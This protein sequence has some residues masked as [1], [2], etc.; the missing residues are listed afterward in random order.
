VL[1]GIEIRKP[2]QPDSTRMRS[3]RTSTRLE[4]NHLDAPNIRSLGSQWARSKE[5]RTSSPSPPALNQLRLILSE[6]GRLAP[7][8]THKPPR[9]SITNCNYF[10]ASRHRDARSAGRAECHRR[11]LRCPH[12]AGCGDSF[13]IESLAA[14]GFVEHDSNSTPAST[15]LR[16]KQQHNLKLDD[17]TR[18][19]QPHH[20]ETRRLGTVTPPRRACSMPIGMSPLHFTY[21]VG[22]AESTRGSVGYDSLRLPPSAARSPAGLTSTGESPMSR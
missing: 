8:F 14:I 12:Q 10:D 11:E 2:V 13:R 21:Q 20:T 9:A 1:E 22:S 15:Q 19:P 4:Q 16:H 5:S 3:I 6:Y 17:S 7:L 18:Q